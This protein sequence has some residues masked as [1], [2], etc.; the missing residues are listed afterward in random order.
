[1]APYY[2]AQIADL[3]N[4]CGTKMTRGHDLILQKLIVSL[5]FSSIN[6]TKLEEDKI[7]QE[8]IEHERRA[9][10]IRHNAPILTAKMTAAQ[11]AE[12]E[13]RKQCEI[14]EKIQ[15]K[16]EFI[17]LE[18]IRERDKIKDQVAML[19]AEKCK[20]EYELM[21]RHRVQDCKNRIVQEDLLLERD[22]LKLEIAMNRKP[23]PKVNNGNVSSA[24]R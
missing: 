14:Q 8:R 9:L 12:N 3:F 20:K 10:L 2:T 6:V 11:N 5:Q 13:H 21:H 24:P 17:I 15:T 7:N 23:K 18:S 19:F 1:M 22:L 4:D 16:Q